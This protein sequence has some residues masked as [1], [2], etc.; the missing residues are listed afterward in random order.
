MP[1]KGGTEKKIRIV[2]MLVTIMTL[3]SLLNDFFGSLFSCLTI[4]WKHL[5]GHTAVPVVEEKEYSLICFF[6]MALAVMVI[7][8]VRRRLQSVF[9]GKAGKWYVVLVIPQI[10][11][12]LVMCVAGWGAGY[13]VLVRSGGNMG[14]FYDQ[15]FSY[16]GFCVLTALSLF[17]VGAYLFGMDR[18]YLEQEK[19][20]QYHAQIT[21]YKLQE[22]QY[23]RAE[24][25]RHDL[26]NHVI[27][28]SGLWEAGEWEKLGKYLRKMENSAELGVSEEATGNRVVD[29]LL[30][31]KRKAAEEKGI[32]WECE[33]KIPRQCALHE[34]DL[35]VLFGNILD[36]AVEACG[37][38]QCKEK[39]NRACPFV[40]IQA[41]AVKKCFFM[42]VKNSTDPAD[43]ERHVFL[44]KTDSKGY[45]IGL[46][47][48]DDVV[49]RY[50]GVLNTEIQ[51]DIFVISILIPME[52]AAHD[53]RR[54]V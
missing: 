28:L 5:A 25:L 45:G 52:D 4:L 29:V 1:S 38:L 54:A 13:G 33:V 53:T 18:M 31:Q 15:I 16:V 11:V 2:S 6:S 48:V 35:C 40:S 46:L 21:A 3:V 20:S 8:A 24:R 7:L 9:R 36:N 49:R 10:V 43:Q 32:A 23:R 17:A 51:D 27:A 50:D 39:G 37:R 26:K 14:L 34:F 22:E 19:S 12:V 30:S 47:N 41:G 42:E 44:H